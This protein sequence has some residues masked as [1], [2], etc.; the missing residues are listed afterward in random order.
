[1]ASTPVVGD[2]RVLWLST[3]QQLMG[4]ASHDVK[5]ALNGVAVNLEVIRGRVERDGLPASALAPFAGAAGQQ[6]ERLTS[7]LEAL[8]AVARAEREPVDVGS[9][10]RRVA[11]LCAASG[12]ARGTVA[13]EGVAGGDAVTRISADAVRLA[14]AAPLLEVVS[15]GREGGAVRCSVHVAPTDIHVRMATEDG[16]VAMPPAVAD[17]LRDAG[18]RWTDDEQEAGVLSLVFPR[19]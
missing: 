8:L 14:I 18:V 15:A 1:M 3:V 4:R 5:D 10:L 9:I 6:L 2:A 7:L 11:A 19:T 17:A 13:V 12:A 16:R